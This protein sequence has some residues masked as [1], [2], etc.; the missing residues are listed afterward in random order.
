MAV[1]ALLSTLAAG[2]VA[3][4]GGLFQ[5]LSGPSDTQDVNEYILFK[6][7]FEEKK[8]LIWKIN[9]KRQFCMVVQWK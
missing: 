3:L 4:I 1:S 8:K 7:K 6:I 2:G 5:H 9:I